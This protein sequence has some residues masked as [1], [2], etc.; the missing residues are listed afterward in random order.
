MVREAYV[1]NYDIFCLVVTRRDADV[2]NT[3]QLMGG[4]ADE[5]IKAKW[6]ECLLEPTRVDVGCPFE[7]DINIASYRNWRRIGGQ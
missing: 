4:Q 5:L 7:V 6:C 2:K 1:V 3:T